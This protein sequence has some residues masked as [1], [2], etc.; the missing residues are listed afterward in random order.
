MRLPCSPRLIKAPRRSALRSFQPRVETLEPRHL[1]AVVLSEFVADN[2]S[3]IRDLDGQRQDW[4]EIA[5]TGASVVDLGGYY[6]SDDAV[7]PAKWQIPAGVTLAAGERLVVFASGKDL[8]SGELH[9]NFSLNNAGEDV[10]L[11]APN[12]VTVVDAY[13]D[14][15]AQEPDAAYG[16]GVLPTT[17]P[18]ETLI[19]V[20][21]PLRAHVPT[22]E[23]AAIDD[24]WREPG[25]NDAAWLSGTRSVGFDRNSD[26]VN[27]APFIGRTLT[28]GEMSTTQ[29]TAYVRFNFDVEGA[30]QLTSLELDLRFDDGFIAYLNGRE[31]ARANFAEDFIRPQPQ[32]DSSAGNQ[33][34]S[35]SSSGAANRLGETLD[36]ASFDLSAYLPSLIEGTN[37][38]AFHVVNSTSSSSNNANRQDLLVEPV[39][40][41]TRATG[42]T[43]IGYLPTPS[44]GAVNG[45]VAEGFV[46]DTKFSVDRGFFDAAFPVEIT[47]ATAS[48]SIRYTTDGSMP[49]PNNGVLYTGP[50]N[51]ASTTTL[52]AIAYKGGWVSTNVDTQTYLFLDDVLQ[53][54]A[55]DVTQPYA[56]WGHDKGDAD[57]AS[58][59][60]LDDESDW[61]MDPDVVNGN[62]AALKDALKS[63]PT[64]SLVMNWDD[65]FGGTPQPGTFPAGSN[66][67][68]QPQ[69]IYIHGS[70]NERGASFEYFDPNSAGDQFQTD[71]G[72]ETQGHSSTLRWNSDKLSMQVKFKF[73]YGPTELNYPVFA[74]AVFGE[75]ATTEFDTLILDAMFNYA[76]HH[77][78]PIQRDYARFVTDQAIS[79]LQ[80]LASGQGAP[81]GEYVHLY[82][83]GM[84]WG[85]YNLHER[86][87]DSFAAAYYGGDKDD[88]D[89]VKHANQDVNHE[90]T[91]V[92]GGVAAE[93]RFSALLDATQAVQNNPAS[94]TA[95]NAVTQQ[96]DVDQ[97]ID[98][99]IVH[100]YGGNAADW[101][102]NNWYAT[103]DR[104]GG[105]WRF[106]AWD[107]EHAF[108]TTDNGDA[109]TQFVDLTTKDDFEAPTS[110]HKN[111]IGNTEYRLRFADRV[112][113]LMQNGG[114]LTNTAAQSVYQARIDEITEAI[115]GESA[116]WGDNRNENDPYT[117]A[118]F[119]AVNNAVIAD[120]FVNR[121]ETV[122]T[123]FANAGWLVPLAA[124]MLSQY[125]G[126]VTGGYDLT[127]SL[128]SGSP[129]GS[130]I[131]YTLDGSDPRLA[132]GAT[133]PS[134]LS[135]AG[136]IVVD[137]TTPLRVLARVKNGADWSPLIDAT[138]TLTDPPA[139][140]V[141]EVMYNPPG[142][143][144]PTEFIEL[145]NFGAETIDLTGFRLEGFSAGGY[146]FTG[147]SLAPGAR[148]VVVA[149][150][151]A[152]AAAYP[153][154]TNVAL[155]VFSGSLANEGETISLRGPVGELIQSFVYGDSN[156]PGWPAAPDG[157]GPSLEYIGP[158]DMD[159]ADPA[160]VAD[161][162]YDDPANWRASFA[163][164]G[165]P[166][167]SGDLPGDY[168]RNGV[169]EQADH[170]VWRTSYGATVTPFMGADGNGDGRIDA[171]DYTVWRDNLTPPTVALVKQAAVATGEP[172]TPATDEAFAVE[173]GPDTFDDVTPLIN[174]TATPI[175]S[176]FAPVTRQAFAI[177]ESASDQAL[178]LL[179]A[180]TARDAERSDITPLKSEEAT[181][182]ER[183]ES[184]AGVRAA[185]RK[186]VAG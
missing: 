124:P 79:D 136:P 52:R 74:D 1:M 138:F 144:D 169:V 83:N 45:V 76:W 67:A 157:D 140:R 117:Q 137:V 102:H 16:V 38:L 174:I 127:L 165:S 23:N 54:S 81:H 130:Q 34:G 128:P 12:G 69:G 92:S 99:M 179:S 107:Q 82:L 8:A 183:P 173:A 154:V 66:V 57:N 148:V 104:N 94:S 164:G 50:I 159:A 77:A 177:S 41:T 3:G 158:F 141:V 112:Q 162:P 118:D 88:Y 160:L 25:F 21:T 123:Q 87:D 96:L 135:G 20:G 2:E 58:G 168:D 73:P 4:I 167:A 11:V 105:L 90:F 95:Y 68:P 133:N 60:N 84:Y 7:T 147:G 39:L 26:G 62:Q 36:I 19:G 70:S 166:G 22:G 78:N 17:Q 9:T 111:L 181:T 63:I 170:L 91:W 43:A 106:H 115:L 59:Y 113:A 156:L 121:T 31:I 40:K 182:A 46:A 61:E 149:D 142:S 153:G 180:M 37:V 56:T 42:A 178:L 172:V 110:I 35:S 116:R 18:Q 30:A 103:R 10:L 49:T 80:N 97:Y 98:Y 155:G 161:D 24:H 33:M 53:Q 14:Y 114:V 109:F 72:V 146:D 51:I 71:V 5:N 13:L 48:A 126:A 108:P 176:R 139:L 101:S 184:M 65:L 175:R 89:V 152:F 120:F 27:L 28:A 47:T 64:V 185:W 32:W 132:G 75:G 44:P 129:G 15:P 163:I 100:Y 55:A 93:D 151:S 6:L 171:A 122:L 134:A 85:L 186:T 119:L 29:T 145:L 143:G 86:P 150:Q 125:G 131:Y